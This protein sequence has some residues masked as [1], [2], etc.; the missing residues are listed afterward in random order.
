MVIKHHI[1][2]LYIV[3][4]PVVQPKAQIYII[5]RHCKPFIQSL[6]LKK[7]RPPHQ[8]ARRSD[9]DQIIHKAV[10]SIIIRLLIV[11]QLELMA[12]SRDGVGDSHVLYQRRTR[13]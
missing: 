6:H 9:A 4:S 3:Q 5:V 2:S 13:I 11:Q 8:K 1:I 7:T 12:G 10:S